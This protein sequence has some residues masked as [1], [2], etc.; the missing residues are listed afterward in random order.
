VARNAALRAAAEVVG[1]L[2]TVLLF[3]VIA[4]RLGADVLGDYVFAT[5]LAQ[6]VWAVAGFGLDRM[7]LRD[8]AR[9][10][11]AI[12]REFVDITV[13]KALAGLTGVGIACAAVA[14]LDYSGEVVALVAIVGVALV[15]GMVLASPQVVFQAYERME[16]YFYS[17]VP[18]KLLAAFAGLAVVLAGGT[19]VAVAW[20]LLAA[21]A[22]SVVVGMWLLY[23]NF[24]RPRMTVAP[25]GW[26]AVIHA[27]T[28][29]GLQEVFGQ[30]VF[31]VDIVLLSLLTSAGVVGAYGASYRLLEATLFLVWSVGTSVLPMF[32]YLK[33]GDSP[34]LS[35]V[36]EG[37]LK[38]ITVVM[39]P[40]AVVLFVC[41]K[42]I[43]S[44]IY[45]LPQYDTSVGVLRWLAFA[46]VAFAAGHIAG[47]L[48]L[49]RRRGRLTVY[50]TAFCAVFNIV[51]NVVLIPPFGA[52]GAAAATLATEVVL[53]AIVIVLARKPVGWPRPWRV[54][55]G[56]VIAGAA[57]AAAMFPVAGSL[58][59]ALPLG[60][61]VYLAV[62][63]LFERRSLSG[64]AD[65]VR[66]LL[67]SGS[68]SAATE[69]PIDA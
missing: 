17:Q 2:G 8:I 35:E 29:F 59:V 26:P 39:V 61:F 60:V 45:G 5:S 24:A 55:G 41:A 37:A 36:Y 3:A 65:F 27:S 63:Y 1:K 28:P 43:I 7:M 42:A 54:A 49:V 22:I 66:S 56:P 50:G 67:R 57:M 23:R 48:V 12:D 68:S 6:I 32:S 46:I 20:S 47:I 16:Y 25:R 13:L 14:L 10:R 58:A 30:I 4:R 62:L 53:A 44:L 21:A 31:R 11:S 34:S 69:P 18:S 9:E 15:L 64:D 51:L 19:I 38:L 52:A 33:P 40:I